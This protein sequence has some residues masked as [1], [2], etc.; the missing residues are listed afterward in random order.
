MNTHQL[1][2]PAAI[3]MQRTCKVFDVDFFLDG[4]PVITPGRETRTPCLMFA[5]LRGPR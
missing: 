1:P 2:M 4:L 3:K 5:A